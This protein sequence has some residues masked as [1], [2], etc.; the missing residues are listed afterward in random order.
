MT[1]EERIEALIKQMSL[2]EKVSMCVGVDNWRTQRIERLGIPALRMTDGPHG[3]R[4]VSDDTPGLTYPA[5]CFPTGSALAATWN[6]ELMEEVGRALAVETKERGSQVLLGPA[7]NIHRHPLNGRNFEYYSEDPHLAGRMA[8]AWIQGLQSEN[9]GAS[10]K[11]FAC[12]NSEYERLTMSSEVDERALHEIYY[13]AFKAAVTEAQPWTVMSSYNRING[14]SSAHNKPMLTDMLK[15]EWGFTGFLVS[16]WGGVYDRLAAAN[17]GCDV[18]MPFKGMFQREQILAGVRSGAISE[19]IID[20][21][22]RRVLRIL[23]RAGLFDAK[24]PAKVSFPK[25]SPYRDLARQAAC[26][27]MALL[28]NNGS[29]L[30]LDARSLKSVAVIGPAAALPLIQ[31][32]GSACVTPYHAVTALDGI[33][34]RCGSGIKVGYEP[35]CAIDGAYPPLQTELTA[36]YFDNP[37]FSGAPV[38]MR[39]AKGIELSKATLPVADL[40][41]QDFS[42]RWTGAFV[43]RHAGVYR[44]SLSSLGSSRIRLD[45]KTIVDN[46]APSFPTT[47][48]PPM[49][50]LTLK[51][52][53]VRLQ[54][55]DKVAL[56]VEFSRNDEPDYRLNAGC[57]GP[58]Q[59]P[60]GRAVELA[61]ASD[62]AIVCIGLPDRYESEGYDRPDMELTGDQA[63][64]IK[65]VAAANKRTVVVVMTGSPITMNDWIGRTPAV[66]QAWYAGQESGDAIAAILFGDVSPS[67]KLPMTMPR[68]LEDTPAYVNYPGENDKVRYGESIFV[69]YRYY[70]KTGVAPLFPFGHGLSYTQFAYGELRLSTKRLA[71]GETL[72]ASVDLTNTGKLAGKEVVQLYV[73]DPVCTHT[74]PPRELKAFKKIELAP[75]QTQTVTFTLTEQDLSFYDPV[76]KAWVAEQGAFTV[77]VGSSSRDLRAKASFT[78]KGQPALPVLSGRSRVADIMSHPKGRAVMRK[79]LGDLRALGRLRWNASYTLDQVSRLSPEFISPQMVKAIEADLAALR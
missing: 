76:R 14:V 31:G 40:A 45:G 9:I 25:I 51:T 20:D 24:A 30:P 66:L 69:G 36:E 57:A 44:F 22:V 33:K 47:F 59:D 1:T 39:T 26:E 43:A 67:G 7:V 8:V 19:S 2:D 64:L 52:G 68:R 11:H 56:T 41:N 32:G 77:M 29:L 37:A 21:K 79:R 61:A 23:F 74:R 42:V 3:A 75:G 50:P 13:P 12:N 34:Q 55:G 5:T 38:A 27:A 17:A 35:G 6:P 28:K 63:T 4:T 62:V 18:E 71:G 49:P 46:W 54:A 72:T 15:N 48:N 53:A 60:L 65:R 10:L 78:F 16:D 70:D 58:L 73:G